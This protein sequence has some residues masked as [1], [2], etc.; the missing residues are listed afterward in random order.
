MPEIYISYNLLKLK[1]PLSWHLNTLT[2]ASENQL[3]SSGSINLKVV[4][5][6]NCLGNRKDVHSLLLNV[7]VIET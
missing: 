2:P 5:I 6:G 1:N 7:F 3:E 4:G